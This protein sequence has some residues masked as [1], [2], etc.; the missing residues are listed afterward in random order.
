MA[1]P[2][3]APSHVCTQCSSSTVPSA[4]ISR[5]RIASC[6]ASDGLR[7]MGITPSMVWSPCRLRATATCF[8][9]TRPR[10]VALKKLTSLVI[11]SV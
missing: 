9:F 3:S 4:L 8:L 11:V 10:T 6:S 2:S 5:P 7:G 1:A